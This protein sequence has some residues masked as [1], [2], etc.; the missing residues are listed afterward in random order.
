MGLKKQVHMGLT[1]PQLYWRICMF[2]WDREKQ[3]M[4]VKLEGFDSQHCAEAEKPSRTTYTLVLGKDAKV[5]L[6]VLKDKSI[7]NYLYTKIKEY[8]PFQGAE[9][10]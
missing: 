3:Y 9:D 4:M 8:P 7:M 10:V 5:N 1:K 2:Q 6:A